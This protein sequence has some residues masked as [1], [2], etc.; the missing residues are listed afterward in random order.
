MASARS[1]L[2]LG[3]S[4]SFGPALARAFGER[5]VARTYLSKPIPGGVRFDA[6][7]S[8]VDEL[9]APLASRPDAAL[10]LLGE[11]RI[12]ACAMEPGR[13]ARINVDGVARV[14][15]ELAARGVKPVFFS[16]DAVF[17]GTRA[18]WTE[19]DAPRPILTYGRQKLQAEGLIAELREPWLIVRLPKLLAGMV[20]GWLKELGEAKRILCATD[21]FFTPADEADAARALVALVDQDARGLVHLP[22]PERLSRRALLDAVVA[23]Y[24]RF[25]EPQAAIVD[26]RLGDIDVKEKRPLDASMRSVRLARLEV[27]PLRAASAAAR[28]LVKARLKS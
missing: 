3:A 16:S 28:E 1:V 26:C 24:R 5:V 21:Q 13:T 7:S 23:E 14:A 25:T 11:T 9:L 20:D 8:S 15:R 22:G 2:L 27:P 12:D 18:F 17:D 6:T 4:G 19:D 10:I